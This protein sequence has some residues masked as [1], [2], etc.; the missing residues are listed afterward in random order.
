MTQEATII[1]AKSLVTSSI[2]LEQ[3]AV[4]LEPTGT[5]NLTELN[6]VYEIRADNDLYNNVF[7]GNIILNDGFVDYDTQGSLNY[8]NPPTFSSSIGDLFNASSSFQSQIDSLVSGSTDPNFYIHTAAVDAFTSSILAASGTFRSELDSLFVVSGTFSDDIDTLFDASSSFSTSI[9]LLEQRTGSVIVRD[10]GID[11]P[12]FPHGILHFRGI[13]ASASNQGS[14]IAELDLRPVHDYVFRPGVTETR[15]VFNTFSGAVAAAN[16][17]EGFKRVICDPISGVLNVPSGSYELKDIELHGPPNVSLA[18]GIAVVNVLDG[19]EF[20]NFRRLRGNILLGYSGTLTP[21]SNDFSG[22]GPQ[23]YIFINDY[24][25][26][27]CNGSQPI[28]SVRAATA[29]LKFIF[30]NLTN[31]SNIFNG[32]PLGNGASPIDLDNDGLLILEAGSFSTVQNA[33]ISGTAGSIFVPRIVD[34]GGNIFLSQSRFTGFF[35]DANATAADR[36]LY[37]PALSVLTSSRVQQAIDEHVNNSQIHFT[38]ASITGQFLST[39]FSTSVA[40]ELAVLQAGSSSFALDIIDLQGASS[41]FSSDINDLQGASSSFASD[42]NILEGASASFSSDVDILIAASGTFRS[43]LDDLNAF[44]T[45][46]DTSFLRVDGTNPMS[47]TL[48]LATNDILSGGEISASALQVQSAPIGAANH[49]DFT[50]TNGPNIDSF[51]LGIDT[52]D[53]GRIV[54]SAQD[55]TFRQATVIAADGVGTSTIFGVACS[56]DGGASWIP[57]VKVRHAGGITFGDDFEVPAGSGSIN[58]HRHY[59]PSGVDPTVPA[60]IA[61]DRY[62][63]TSL[64]MEM[65]YDGFRS[66]WLSVAENALMAGRNGTVPS[67]VYLRGVNGLVLSPTRGYLAQYNGT[68]AGVSFTRDSGT[69]ALEITSNGTV[70]ATIYT[71]GASGKINTLNVDFSEDDILAVKNAATAS[72]ANV[73]CVFRVKWRV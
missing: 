13:I 62:Y 61:G 48:D 35:F 69:S 36:L 25:S 49:V 31:G 70:V 54:A 26:I 10:N 14:S 9:G 23:D 17:I 5:I 51:N 21:L 32:V 2:D 6:E 27:R 47:G 58:S 11:L 46:V 55:F 24:A 72:M 59:S 20:K 53:S 16:Q 44:S 34:T 12:D 19:A 68:I 56:S 22:P 1:I 41:S 43:E 67:N 64:N 40:S 63:N 71:S 50:V 3:L 29:G 15:N 66:K 73:Q 18:G 37:N 65:R 52:T 7:S 33:S 39:S 57:R 60:P 8:L 38:T 30:L 4:S 28:F 42:I 45:S